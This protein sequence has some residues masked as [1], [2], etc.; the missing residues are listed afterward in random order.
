MTRTAEGTFTV[1]DPF[2]TERLPQQLS[3]RSGAPE[4][5]HL[6]VKPEPALTEC[7]PSASLI[8]ARKTSFRTPAGRKKRGDEDT[9]LRG[10]R[11]SACRNHAVNMRMQLQLLIPCVEQLKNPISVP[12]LSGLL[13][14]SISVV[15]LAS[16][17]RS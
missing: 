13:P 8:L 4:R 3:K 9:H 12:R 16:N 11:D 5:F 6:P 14:T 7:G 1:D 2:L 10:R 15:A 17:K